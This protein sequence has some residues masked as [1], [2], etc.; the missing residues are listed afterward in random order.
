MLDM[1]AYKNGRTITRHEKLKCLHEC[2]EYCLKDLSNEA[3]KGIPVRTKDRTKLHSHFLL[4]SYIGDLPECEDMCSVKRNGNTI[5]PCHRCLI[6]KCQLPFNN[7]GR[8][9][10]LRVSMDIIRRIQNGDTDAY[11]ELKKLS[12]LPIAPVF[13]N[14]PMVGLTP[15]V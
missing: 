3:V 12:M 15:A 8:E 2:I 5:S 11:V 13:H 9:R 6:S 14:F 4:S 10:S 7:N 1:A